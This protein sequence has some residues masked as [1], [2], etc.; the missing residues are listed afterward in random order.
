MK[1]THAMRTCYS[2][3]E[4]ALALLDDGISEEALE[5]ALA[6]SQVHAVAGLNDADLPFAIAE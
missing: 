4:M 6:A 2:P 3:L 5:G 1:G